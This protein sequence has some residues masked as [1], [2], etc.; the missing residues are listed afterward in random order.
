MSRAVALHVALLAGVLS[1]CH[2]PLPVTPRPP[3][4]SELAAPRFD[5]LVAEGCYLCLHDVLDAFQQLPSDQQNAPVLA[6][7]VTRAS[8]LLMLRTKE[9]GIPPDAAW[10]AA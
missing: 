5:A 10:A 8:L 9:L 3:T 7:V 1:A 6:P 2:R 4:A